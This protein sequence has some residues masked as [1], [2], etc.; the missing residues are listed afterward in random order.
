[1]QD[2]RKISLC[3]TNYNRYELLLKSFEKVLNDDRISEIIISD[4]CSDWEIWDK[5]VEYYVKIE[6]IFLLRSNSINIGM[7]RNK[8][9]SIRYSDNPW[10]IIFDSDNIIDFNYIDQ[11]YKIPHWN[12]DTIYSPS[13]ALP[14]FDYSKYSGQEITKDN[15]K[16]FIGQREFDCLMNTCNY[17]VHRDTYLK[18][19]IYDPTIK[20][21]DT[22]WH[23][24]N[25]LKNG[26]K[27]QVVPEMT[28][29]HLVHEGSG[30]LEN[31][32]EN[33]VKA[34]EIKELIRGL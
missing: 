28:Y 18:T 32:Q 19:Y 24:Y 26:G 2:N 25:H 14:N 3:L 33:I 23:N 31:A 1:M 12:E 10:C 7:S 5:L 16:E 22:I 13:G 4:D 9:Q 17:F 34:N 20:Q 30:W 8:T 11:L 29:S 6:K 15:A 27:I 21:S